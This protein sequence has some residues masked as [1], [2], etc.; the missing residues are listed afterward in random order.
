MFNEASHHSPSIIFIDELD[1]MAPKRGETGAHA[2][3]R[4]VTQLLSLMDGLTR[5]DSVIVIGTTNRID[6]VD[7]AFRRPGRFALEIFVG[8]PDVQGRREILEIQ[9]REM[10]LT[11]DAQQ[12]LDEVARRTHGFV[13]ADLMELCRNAGLSALRRSTLNLEDPK[14][15]FRIDMTKRRVDRQDFDAA[16]G[17]VRPSAMR[18]TL[19][20]IPEVKWDDI[21]GLD[22]VKA[23]LKEL[24]EQ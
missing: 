18:E 22:S 9:T 7:P 6:S 17:Q 2:D 11:D 5:V 12:G 21:G 19:I 16:V 1:A 10:P 8:P 3:T 14:A 23:R 13:G 4:A 24:M 15:A 20:S